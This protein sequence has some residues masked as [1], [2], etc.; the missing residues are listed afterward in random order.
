MI[1]ET[2]FGESYVDAWWCAVNT[3]MPFDTTVAVSTSPMVVE[4]TFKGVEVIVLD[5]PVTVT[6]GFTNATVIANHYEQHIVP[7]TRARSAHHRRQPRI[8]HRRRTRA[9]RVPRTPLLV[10]DDPPPTCSAGTRGMP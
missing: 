7:S 6:R 9:R 10:G 2:F 1:L 5:K 8:L 3:V 4:R